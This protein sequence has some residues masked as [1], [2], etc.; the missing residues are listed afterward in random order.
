MNER[1]RF[2]RTMRFQPVDRFPLWGSLGLW[3]QTYQR[4][5]KEGFPAI[6]EGEFFGYDRQM[7]LPI[8][9]GFVPPLKRRQ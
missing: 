3:P 1:E 7:T 9:F 5:R 6:T 2:L 4:W 8:D